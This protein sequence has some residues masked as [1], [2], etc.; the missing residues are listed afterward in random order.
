MPNEIVS[1]FL[2]FLG[3]S[4]DLCLYLS[5]L[6][7]SHQFQHSKGQT[8]ACVSLLVGFNL[9]QYTTQSSSQL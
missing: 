8:K 5:E 6:T 7:S 3:R 2:G 9:F 4:C 1:R